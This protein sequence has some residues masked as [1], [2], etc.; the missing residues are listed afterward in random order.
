[1]DNFTLLCA[2]DDLEA[3]EDIKYLLN[4]YFVEVYTATNGEMLMIYM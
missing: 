4:R 1:M 3:L 2:E